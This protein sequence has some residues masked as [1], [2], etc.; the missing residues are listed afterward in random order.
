MLR[1]KVQEA[2]E[3]LV[4]TEKTWRQKMAKQRDTFSKDIAKLREENAAER[5]ALELEQEEHEATRRR[6]E[7]ERQRGE[8]NVHKLSEC[9]VKIARLERVVEDLEQIV[10][11]GRL[12]LAEAKED[13]DEQGKRMEAE[14][15]DVKNLLA[16]AVSKNEIRE[17]AFSRNWTASQWRTAMNA[18]ERGVVEGA[19]GGG[20]E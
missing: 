15:I 3:D 1:R 13:R 6:L 17:D 10:E 18:G 12:A 20:D 9:E 14:L 8:E 16:E 7:E 11:G 2:Q 5:R 19:P 4:E